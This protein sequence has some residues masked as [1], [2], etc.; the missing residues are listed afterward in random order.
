M[1]QI[2]QHSKRILIV[3][4]NDQIRQT[5]IDYFCP[6][7]DCEEANSI[8]TALENLGEKDFEV[9][10]SNYELRDVNALELLTSIQ[11]LSPETSVVL[12]GRETQTKDVIE[13]FRTGVFDFIEQPFELDEL[14]GAIEKAI[15]RCKTKTTKESYEK[16]LENKIAEQKEAIDQA[17]RNTENSYGAMLKALIQALEARDS[18]THGHSERVVTFSLRLAHE[19]GLVER[20]MRDLELGSLLHDIGKIGVPDAILRKPGK[21]TEREWGKMK[22]H[23]QLGAKIL[24]NIPFLKGASRIVAEH[25]ERW[26]GS[27][28]PNQI[29]G[30]EIS[31][32]ARIFSVADAFDAMISDRVYRKGRSFEDAVAELDKYAG[33]QFDPV[34]VEAFK[35]IP[36]ED[37]ENLKVRSLKDKQEIFSSKEIVAELVN[38]QNYFEMVH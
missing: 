8:T 17:L 33:T 2:E 20:E 22:L 21:L 28:Y 13:A 15:I 24:R 25:H 34:I 18:E 35:N 3:E 38:S 5:L 10:V 11:F 6:K 19:V 16:H 27:G 9:I 26:D 32:I 29:R 1:F 31:L 23:P 30:E 7:Y 37:W 36:K 14:E 12:I 4:P